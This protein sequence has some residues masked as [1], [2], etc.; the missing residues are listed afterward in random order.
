MR[1]LLVVVVLCCL[2]TTG[3][4]AILGKVTVTADQAPVMSGKDLLMTVR[5]GESFDVIEVKGDWYGL[6]PSKG[7]IHKANVWFESA[8]AGGSPSAAPTAGEVP[9]KPVSPPASSKPTFD[10]TTDLAEEE[11]HAAEFAIKMGADFEKIKCLIGLSSKKFNIIEVHEIMA[12]ISLAAKSFILKDRTN[13]V[14][15]LTA[16]K[17]TFNAA[18]ENITEEKIKEGEALLIDKTSDYPKAVA[19]I[20]LVGSASEFVTERGKINREAFDKALT[21]LNP[22]RIAQCLR[23]V[24]NPQKGEPLNVLM[25]A[26]GWYVDK[27]GRFDD[28]TFNKALDAVKPEDV[29]A[30]MKKEETADK[31]QA[32]LLILLKKAGH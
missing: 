20:C 31:T 26:S 11:V 1:K 16:N 9:P 25:K 14:N 15:H 2:V 10:S 12:S 27:S 22:A 24:D 32:L 8:T 17:E 21:N 29:E 23:L 3:Q 4:A 18:V 6:S 7:W 5:K 30:T 19:F 28:L 13:E